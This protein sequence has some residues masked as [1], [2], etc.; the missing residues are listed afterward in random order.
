MRQLISLFEKTLS[1]N[2][3]IFLRAVHGI[4]M[5]PIRDTI[6]AKNPPIATW[7]LILANSFVFLFELT[8]SPQQL[9]QLF[10][11]FGIVPARFSHP[12]W[13]QWAGFPID[14]YWPF[15]TSMF[16]HGG[17]MHIITNMWSLWVFGDNVHD[18]MGPL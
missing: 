17:W 7:F 11:L 9:E 12:D 10:Y 6:P 1:R 14:N 4:K 13:A 18:A 8:L 5:F 3:T 15:L 16:L 2:R